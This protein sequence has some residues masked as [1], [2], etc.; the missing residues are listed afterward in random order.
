MVVVKLVLKVGHWSSGTT[1]NQLGIVEMIDLSEVGVILHRCGDEFRHFETD[2]RG[3]SRWHSRRAESACC[4]NP[5]RA[6]KNAS[7]WPW[8]SPVSV[9]K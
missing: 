2:F 5:N 4:A 7:L 9:R 1:G 6:L 8:K 3:Q